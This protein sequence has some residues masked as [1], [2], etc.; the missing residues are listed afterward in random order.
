MFHVEW[1]EDL[2]GEKAYN[3][4]IELKLVLIRK[5]DYA[6]SDISKHYREQARIIQGQR[7]AGETGRIEFT[8]Y[9]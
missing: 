5:K 1:F 2:I 4:L 9:F 6:E 7:E 8:G 3:I